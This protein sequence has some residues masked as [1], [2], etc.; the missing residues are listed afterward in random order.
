[1]DVLPARD[2][3]STDSSDVSDLQPGKAA[4]KGQ[5]Y[6]AEVLAVGKFALYNYWH[7]FDVPTDLYT[8]L[9]RTIAIPSTTCVHNPLYNHSLLSCR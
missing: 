9:A 7:R 1:M 2:I 4:F 5:P 8:M 3:T 6:D